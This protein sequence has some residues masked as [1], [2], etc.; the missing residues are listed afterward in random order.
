M[1]N[2]FITFET[3]H[4]I[5]QAFQFLPK[6]DR[7]RHRWMVGE[8]SAVILRDENGY[9]LGTFIYQGGEWVFYLAGQEPA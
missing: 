8:E 4:F 2:D 3:S 9:I 6:P 1:R 7:D 5:D